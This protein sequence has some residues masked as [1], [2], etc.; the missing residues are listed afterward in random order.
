MAGAGQARDGAPGRY[1][2]RPP[3]QSVLY[4]C[5]RQHLKTGL[6][7]LHIGPGKS[8]R[9]TLLAIT[10]RVVGFPVLWQISIVETLDVEHPV[11]TGGGCN[12]R[13]PRSIRSRDPRLG[14]AKW[15]DRL[16][17]AISRAI[18]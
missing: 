7:E 12:A 15:A 8:R 13:L 1:T 2:L 17:D 5:V 6:A 4:R 11:A 16:A 3:S 14:W 10:R 18:P 9:D